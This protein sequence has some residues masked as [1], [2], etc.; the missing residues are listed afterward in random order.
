MSNVETKK[1]EGHR[2]KVATKAETN[3]PVTASPDFFSNRQMIPAH[4]QKELDEQGL[5]GRFLSLKMLGDSGGYHPKGW[6]PYV[7]KNPIPNPIT[8]NADKTY[9]VGDLVLGVKTKELHAQHRAYLDQRAKMQSLE[10]KKGI[11]EMRD[12]I[13]ESRSEKH[14]S[15]IEG[16]EENGGD[17]D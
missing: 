8:G 17:E 7:L 4:I 3:K 6:T 2:Q 1:M 10:G 14:I 9:R 15:L 12:R 13:R 11:Q 16:Y 5:V